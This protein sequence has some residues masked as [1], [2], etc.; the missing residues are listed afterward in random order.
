[1]FERRVST[2]QQH[3][4]CKSQ[5]PEVYYTNEI[6]QNLFFPTKIVFKNS[7]YHSSH[8]SKQGQEQYETT[9]EQLHLIA[10]SST[11]NSPVQR[12]DL[13]ACPPITRFL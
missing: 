6:L 4:I 8:Q 1:M 13:I 3:N 12:V 11:P 5:S 7:Q 2:S 10:K 9:P